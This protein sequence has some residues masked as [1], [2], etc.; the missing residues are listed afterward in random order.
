MLSESSMTMTRDMRLRPLS[1]APR[2]VADKTGRA[3]A[4]TRTTMAS[5]RTIR[6]MSCSMRNRRRL[7]L[8]VSLRYF[9][10]AQSM[11]WKRRR[12]RRWMMIGTLASVRKPRRA[13][14][15]NGMRSYVQ[16]LT[17]QI[18]NPKSKI[19]TK[20]ET[21]SSKS[22]NKRG[23][24][25]HVKKWSG[26]WALRRLGLGAAHGAENQV[27]LFGLLIEFGRFVAHCRYGCHDHSQEMS[28]LA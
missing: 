19:Q 2:P 14:A 9:I 28:R 26:S 25:P 16:K 12:F 21:R 4:Q 24:V 20:S 17:N 10:G 23:D 13:G 5:V 27:E 15:K 3:M 11:R 18:Q 7:V 6:R 1:Q 22:E 8:I